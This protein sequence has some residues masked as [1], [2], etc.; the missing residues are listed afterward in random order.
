MSE[1]DKSVAQLQRAK[2]LFLDRDGVLNRRIV[3][4]YVRHPNQVDW[5]PGVLEAL[6]SLTQHFERTFVVT[7]QQGVGRN[8]MTLAD[9]F[10]VHARMLRA[11]EA[12]GARVDG[13]YAATSLA[14]SA[15]PAR[16]PGPAMGMFAQAEF[17]EVD[18]AA[19][20]LVGD[21]PSDMDFGRGLGMLACVGVGT[22][23]PTGADFKFVDLPAFSSFLLQTGD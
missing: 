11:I 15:A 16:K 18:F 13:V 14:A 6:P 21:S 4:D 7:N 2:Y 19:S 3:G 9:L 23:V 5:L 1:H 20:I 8:L 17:P 10:A 22:P 12:A